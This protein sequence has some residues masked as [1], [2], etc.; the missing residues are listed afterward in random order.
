MSSKNL[1]KDL[2]ALSPA[3]LKIFVW[4]FGVVKQNALIGIDVVEPHHRALKR[5]LVDYRPAAPKL[6]SLLDALADANRRVSHAR[7]SSKGVQALVTPVYADREQLMAQ[8]TV[9]GMA[10][11][12]PMNI[13]D[14]IREGTGKIDAAEDVLAI[15]ALVE[16]Y[17]SVKGAFVGSMA[18]LDEKVERARN[19]LA[20]L[21]PTGTAARP[22][23][24]L[25]Q[26]L[27]HESRVWVLVQRQHEVLWQDAVRIFG[28]AVDEHV[29]SLVSRSFKRRAVTPEPIAPT[30]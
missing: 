11:L 14:R 23:L 10:G 20:L 6:L 22:N 9:W 7:P 24:E 19:A 17:P 8:L 12:V 13:V 26:A 3:D 30:G 29:P 1:V 28:R 5:I 16:Q 25:D 21:K 15:A 18:S 27:D 2:A 4:S